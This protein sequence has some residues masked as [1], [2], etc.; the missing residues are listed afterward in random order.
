MFLLYAAGNSQVRIKPPPLQICD[1]IYIY[2]CSTGSKQEE[3]EGIVHTTTVPRW[4]AISS[5]ERIGQEEV[6]KWSLC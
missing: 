6:G 2:A 1:G 4:T 5:S 3:L